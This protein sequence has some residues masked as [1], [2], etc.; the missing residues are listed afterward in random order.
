MSRKKISVLLLTLLLFDFCQVGLFNK[1]DEHFEEFTKDGFSS[2][3]YRSVSAV[4]VCNFCMA[5]LLSGGVFVFVAHR[6]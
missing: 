6:R 5:F 4:T 3:S 1:D 2:G